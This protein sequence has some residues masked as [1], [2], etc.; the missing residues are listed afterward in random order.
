M[1]VAG[2]H[3]P[4]GARLLFLEVEVPK[5]QLVV[6]ENVATSQTVANGVFQSE[7]RNQVCAGQNK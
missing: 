6:E 5:S 7:R 2:C 3:R 4:T 1:P